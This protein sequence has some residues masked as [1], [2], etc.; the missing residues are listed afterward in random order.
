MIVLDVDSTSRSPSLTIFS[1]KLYRL[2]DLA[3]ATKISLPVR[4]YVLPF[5]QCSVGLLPFPSSDI[6]ASVADMVYRENGG[7]LPPIHRIGTS[8][9]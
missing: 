2:L 3:L 1:L 7:P 6:S 9:R 5:S 4:T 8:A